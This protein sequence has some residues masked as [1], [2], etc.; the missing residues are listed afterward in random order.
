[1][2]KTDLHYKLLIL[3]QKIDYFAQACKNLTEE[4]ISKRN[5]IIK[6]A[7]WKM[8][9]MDFLSLEALTFHQICYA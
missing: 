5:N 6:R 9:A 4:N 2:M 1:M 7:L 3:T 8:Q